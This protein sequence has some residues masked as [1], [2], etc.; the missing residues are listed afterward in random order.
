MSITARLID[1]AIEYIDKNWGNSDKISKRMGARVVNLL[2]VPV[3]AITCALDIILGLAVGLW[4][5]CTL[6]THK[7]AKRK[8]MSLLGNSEKLIAGPFMLFLKAFNLK[9]QFEKK[10]DRLAAAWL[11]NTIGLAA[12]DHTESKNLLK[13]HVTSRLCFALI[14][15]SH[16][17][18]SIAE[19]I[20]G[21][22]AASFSIITLAQVECIN[23]LAYKS[24]HA[25][26]VILDLFAGALN[27]I[28]PWTFN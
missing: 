4:L 14:A 28:N 7:A 6:G 5:T 12:F 2:L 15:I 20:I 3:Y 8:M 16:L 18:L 22:I 27:I 17:T 26:G 19:G 11:D 10:P 13:K 21:I 23:A 9:Q 24:L 25:S 1:P